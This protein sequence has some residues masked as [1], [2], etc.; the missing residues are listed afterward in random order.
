[1]NEIKP[2][3]SYF[4]FLSRLI[5]KRKLII[6]VFFTF[7]IFSFLLALSLIFINY[8]GSD[9]FYDYKSFFNVFMPMSISSTLVGNS[10][11][12]IL[13]FLIAFKDGESDGT[14]LLII[15]K[16]I[17]R[18][19]IVLTRMIF[20]SV[21]S[22]FIGLISLAFSGIAYEIINSNKFHFL[23]NKN[24]YL[25]GMFG[26]SILSFFIF[27]FIATGFSLFLSGK[28]TRILTVII[29][30]VSSFLFFFSQNLNDIIR[31]PSISSF[32]NNM[33]NNLNEKYKGK[34]VID[35]EDNFFDDSALIKNIEIEE[36]YLSVKTINWN[37][38]MY[39]FIDLADSS[40]AIKVW[41]INTNYNRDSYTTV[42]AK[43]I[44]DEL[45]YGILHSMNNVIWASGFT[46]IN[47]LNPVSAL[48]ELA[49]SADFSLFNNIP[50]NLSSKDWNLK[51]S[52]N[53]GEITYFCELTKANPSWATSLLWITI[54]MS[55]GTIIFISYL[56]KDFK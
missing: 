42:Q 55:L 25:L 2:I 9:P 36:R 24:M 30:F 8:T 39:A 6:I 22:I 17:T 46:A 48:S 26:S 21:L 43:K 4:G 5:L 40:S 10:L 50:Y 44:S 19:Q 37:N 11:V 52:Y 14:E 41:Y 7:L 28:N 35:L 38:K 13:S 51:K 18:V 34:K 23:Y 29:L 45:W 47:Y 20:F 16:P 54:L 1:M 12:G 15:S 32:A 53:S 56:R 3:L 31:S 27:G 33:Q 49:F